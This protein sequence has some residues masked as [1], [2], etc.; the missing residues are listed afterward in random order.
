[1][2][3]GIRFTV[4]ITLLLVLGTLLAPASARGADAALFRLFL[5]DGT[6]MVSYGEYARVDDRVIFSMP[7]G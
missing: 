7:V 6:A 5:T 3:L 1:M 2:R 4:R